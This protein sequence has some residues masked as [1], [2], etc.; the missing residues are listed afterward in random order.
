M[1]NGQTAAGVRIALR[2]ATDA[3]A[4]TSLPETTRTMCGK[5]TRTITARVA[6]IKEGIGRMTGGRTTTAE[7]REEICAKAD[8]TTLI[9]ATRTA[10]G[11]VAGT[12][13]VPL[14][15]TVD[16]G[17]TKIGEAATRNGGTE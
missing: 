5:G 13:I 10:A 8:R 1:M 9:V 12:R 11:T 6:G 15:A 17:Q 16:A 4:E 7:A 2:A 14:T 3:V